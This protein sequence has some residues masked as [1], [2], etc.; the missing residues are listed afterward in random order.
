VIISDRKLN[1]NH[2]ESEQSILKDKRK[3]IRVIISH[4]VPSSKL[5]GKR[6]K[7]LFAKFELEE[8]DK[9]N[10][11]FVFKECSLICS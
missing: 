1:T 10:S 7:I 8:L 4:K 5:R 3:R 6:T 2:E 9:K 11:V